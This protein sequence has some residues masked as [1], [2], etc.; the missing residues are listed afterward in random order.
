MKFSYE[1]GTR[2]HLMMMAF[3]ITSCINFAIV[4]EI[5]WLTIE[6]ELV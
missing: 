6:N 1:I 4:D 3:F 2:S 5:Q